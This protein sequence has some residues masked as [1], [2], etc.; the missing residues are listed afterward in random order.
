MLLNLQL[1][2]LAGLLVGRS[3][4]LRDSPQGRRMARERMQNPDR[5]IARGEPQRDLL[6]LILSF[7]NVHLGNGGGGGSVSIES[8]AVKA[9]V[10]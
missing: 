2:R 6:P 10:R 9:H 7:K 1:N 8:V 3:G 4:P 5:I